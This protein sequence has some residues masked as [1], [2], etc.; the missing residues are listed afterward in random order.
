MAGRPK[1]NI[2]WDLVDEYLSAH[3][4]GAAIAGLIGIHPETLYDAVKAKYNTNFSDYAQKKRAEGVAM[5]ENSLYRDALSKGGVDRLF[6]LKNKAAWQDKQDH[7][8]TGNLNLHFD[9]EDEK[10]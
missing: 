2:D 5:V 6:W 9:K 1:A 4:D 8:I 10:L 3:C 7:N